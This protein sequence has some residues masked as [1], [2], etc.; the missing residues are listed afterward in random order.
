VAA[1]IV[2]AVGVVALAGCSSGGE[3]G[4]TMVTGRTST[5]FVTLPPPTTTTPAAGGLDDVGT[6]DPSGD[7]DQVAQ[8]PGVYTIR[9][10][11]VLV[12]IARNFGVTVDDLVAYN[13]WEDGLDH[14]LSPG[15]E[16]RIPP[17]GY[18]PDATA[19]DAPSDASEST[20]ADDRVCADGS[21]PET[22]TIRAGDT[23][24]R[25][26]ARF[27]VTIEDLDAVNADTQFYAGFVI[28]IEILIPC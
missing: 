12:N 28:G 20:E 27:D 3:A 8:D 5:T 9:R 15:D 11:D 2:A 7:D 17:D 19:P 1:R 16:I 18:D 13:E 25:V 26:A 21:E 22:Y 24:G 23:R 6:G 14:F 4:I 10:G